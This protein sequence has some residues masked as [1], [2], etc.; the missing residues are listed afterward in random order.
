MRAAKNG[1]SEQVEDFFTLP[2]TELD[3]R[4]SSSI[5]GSLIRGKS[6]S[7]RAKK[8]VRV[9]DV[10]QDAVAL[11]LVEEIEDGEKRR[12]G[13]KSR[14]AREKE[15]ALVKDAVRCRTSP[16]HLIG[17]K[18]GKRKEGGE[19]KGARA[20]SPPPLALACSRSPHACPSPAPPAR[21]PRRLATN[22]PPA[23]TQDA[24]ASTPRI[25]P[26][27][28]L[29]APLRSTPAGPSCTVCTSPPQPF[30]IAHRHRA[31]DLR[32][33]NQ[34][35]LPGHQPP[36]ILAAVAHLPLHLAPGLSP[37]PTPQ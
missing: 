37:H 9:K 15:K 35:P 16:L 36:G 28:A 6:V 26:R 3:Q 24:C 29:P 23:P 11:V 1:A 30:R 20:P 32:E 17:G 8:T 19:E 25:H 27:Q 12:H 13:G 2:T 10:E 33:R 7:Q 14:E 34:Q 5:M 18:S 22:P 31:T 21:T 4:S